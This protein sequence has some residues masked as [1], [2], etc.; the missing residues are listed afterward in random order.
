MLKSI[1]EVKLVAKVGISYA[2]V[3]GARG[4]IALE[5]PH[6][7]FDQVKSEAETL[8]RNQLEKITV[9]DNDKVEKTKFYTA[10]YHSFMAPHLFSDAN[11]EYYGADGKTQKAEGYQR[12]T[13]F[14]L[15]DTF[16]ALHPLLTITNPEMVD[17]LVR[18]M[19]AF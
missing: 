11:G 12:Y 13:L 16:R 14:S 15:W 17:D 10:L 1:S 9:K 7:D 3:D 5:V 6:F 4:N 18:S 19:M 8:W 2:S